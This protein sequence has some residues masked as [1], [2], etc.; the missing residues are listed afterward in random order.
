MLVFTMNIPLEN[1][2]KSKRKYR[3]FWSIMKIDFL[4]MID[5]DKFGEW[6][7]KIEET[8][9]FCNFKMKQLARYS[10]DAKYNIQDNFQQSFIIDN[11]C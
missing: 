8:G 11:S 9:D 2:N 7:V 3:Y 4:R 5:I 6:T 1:I 10:C